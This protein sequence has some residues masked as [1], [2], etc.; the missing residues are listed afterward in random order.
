MTE[1]AIDSDGAS[2]H[3]SSVGNGGANNIS[4]SPGEKSLYS[5]RGEFMFVTRFVD[6]QYDVFSLGNLILVFAGNS[7]AIS[8]V[9]LSPERTKK[10]KSY[11]PLSK[12]MLDGD[13]SD[14]G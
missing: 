12:L 4:V 3:F 7:E 8:C 1:V 6:K 13:F 2:P 11:F 14:W 10:R 9:F 5:G